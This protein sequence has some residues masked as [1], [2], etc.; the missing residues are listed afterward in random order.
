[1]EQSLFLGRIENPIQLQS[2][3][4]N[5]VLCTGRR[6]FGKNITWSFRGSRIYNSKFIAKYPS[7]GTYFGRCFVPKN[8]V[9]VCL[10]ALTASFV[11]FVASRC[12]F[13]SVLKWNRLWTH[14]PENLCSPTRTAC[15]EEQG[16]FENCA[17]DRKNV[18]LKTPSKSWYVC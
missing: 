8:R 1:M 13:Q 14:E 11:R 6:G 16:D 15:A 17:S 18:A 3:L 9:H 4:G 5:N 7:N 10:T 2:C 12:T